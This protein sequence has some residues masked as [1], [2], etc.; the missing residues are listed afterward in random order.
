MSCP[1]CGSERVERLSIAAKA[2]V[3]LGGLVGDT[4]AEIGAVV[5]G[6]I[7]ALFGTFPGEVKTVVAKP[8]TRQPMKCNSCNHEWHD[9]Y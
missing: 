5:G 1:K 2:G 8:M 6:F 4:G 7:G 3:A 9:I